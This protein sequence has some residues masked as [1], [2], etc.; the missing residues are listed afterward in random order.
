MRASVNE[1][2][3]VQGTFAPGSETLIKDIEVTSDGMP[4]A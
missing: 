2:I 3:S 1:A 4:Q